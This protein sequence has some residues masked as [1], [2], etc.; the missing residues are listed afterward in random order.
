M[1]RNFNSR[2]EPD[3]EHSDDD[4]AA[5]DASSELTELDREEFPDYFV[6]RDGRLF[7][8]H[9]GPYPL[10]VDGPEQGVS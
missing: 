10:P 3:V 2:V 7:P 8:S 1:T 6:E 5:S 9:G 4:D